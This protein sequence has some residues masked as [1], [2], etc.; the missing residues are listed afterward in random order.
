MAVRAYRAFAWVEINMKLSE[1]PW[2]TR[3]ARLMGMSFVIWLMLRPGYWPFAA[4]GDADN[5]ELLQRANQ[6]LWAG[7][8]LI[9]IYSADVVAFIIGGRPDEETTSSPFWPGNSFWPA[10]IGTLMAK[11]FVDVTF[12]SRPLPEGSETFFAY[13]RYVDITALVLLPVVYFI[14][15]RLGPFANWSIVKALV[16]EPP[17]EGSSREPAQ[18]ESRA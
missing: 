15:Q 12:A 11:T 17:V 5:V 3:L 2:K 10:L 18:F 8:V 7:V 9:A 13:E 14:A 6:F 16:L 1:Y 4:F